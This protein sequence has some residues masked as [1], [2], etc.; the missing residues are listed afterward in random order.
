M[1]GAVTEVGGVEL[2]TA[3]TQTLGTNM[4][5]IIITLILVLFFTRTFACSCEW[6]KPALEFYSS[7][8][9]FEGKAVSKEYTS[10]SLT[11]TISFEILKHYKNGDYPKKMDFTL[12]SEGKYTGEWTSCDWNVEIGENWLVY[13]NYRNGKLTFGYYCS[14]SKP[15]DKRIISEKEQRVLDNGNSFAIDNYI[16]F[17]ENNFNYSKPLTN[18]D[19]ILSL[20]KVK[21]YENPHAYLKLLIDEKGYLKKVTTLRSYD[22]KTDS[23]FNLPAEFNVSIKKPF[24]EFQK[25]AIDLVSQISKW[26]I[27]RYKTSNIPVTYIRGFSIAFDNETQK[28]KYEL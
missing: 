23:I 21:N 18:I 9:V 11:Y 25:D 15:I 8:Y 6:P 2:R 17:G 24:T 4:K 28:W 20:G 22:I 27:K 1:V 7:E 26:E 3:H 16:Y 10:D 5:K 14:N 12:K 19:S 13:T